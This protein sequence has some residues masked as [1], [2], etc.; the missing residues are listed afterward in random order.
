MFE[1]ES[2]V[3]LFHKKSKDPETSLVPDTKVIY[4]WNDDLDRL[5]SHTARISPQKDG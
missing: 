3:V 2:N 5:V 1:Q 4:H